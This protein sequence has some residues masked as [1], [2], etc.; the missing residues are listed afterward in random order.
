[1]FLQVSVC[2]QGGLPASPPSRET[3]QQGDPLARRPPWQG[4]PKME[5][6][7]QGDPQQGD[8]PA[9]RPPWQ[10]DPLARRPPSKETPQQGDTP[11]PRRQ[12]PQRRPPQQGDPP[13]EHAERYGQRAGGTHP[14]GMQ[15]CTRL[16][17][18][19]FVQKS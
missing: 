12:S 11:L 15:S 16:L 3:P 5:T 10:G 18:F 8:P 2:P 6:P 1:M 14:T 17:F 7:W 13:A 19:P 4:G 9:R